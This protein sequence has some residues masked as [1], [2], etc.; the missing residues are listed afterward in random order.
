MA[1][2]AIFKIYPSR[3]KYER[4]SSDTR[5]ITRQDLSMA[6]SQILDFPEQ[7]VNISIFWLPYDSVSPENMGVMLAEVTIDNRLHNRLTNEGQRRL[8]SRLKRV[9]DARFE[10]YFTVILNKA[11]I[12]DQKA[13]S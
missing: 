6:L 2:D 12:R 10:S 5:R 4:L 3:E 7:I 11:D 9:L 8:T 13:S 1:F